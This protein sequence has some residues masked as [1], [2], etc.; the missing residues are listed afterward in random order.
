[1]ASVCGAPSLNEVYKFFKRK[2]GL[3]HK[4]SDLWLQFYAAKF[5]CYYNAKYW[6][7]EKGNSV[8]YEWRK[9]AAH[10]YNKTLVESNKFSK[11]DENRNHCSKK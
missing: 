6:H 5:F 11:V 8:V 1:M 4:H 2:D 3:L 9:L 7:D 10:E